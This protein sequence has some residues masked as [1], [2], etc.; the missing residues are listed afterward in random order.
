MGS[1]MKLSGSETF[2]QTGPGRSV[3]EVEDPRLV[4]A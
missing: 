3:V 2:Q 4:D 1:D